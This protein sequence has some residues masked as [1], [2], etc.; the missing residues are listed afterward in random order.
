VIVWAYNGSE[1]KQKYWELQKCKGIDQ[2]SR[3]MATKSMT[4]LEG[5]IRED[6]WDLVICI[7]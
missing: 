4:E 6:Q 3:C 1:T 7:K 2:G 5:K